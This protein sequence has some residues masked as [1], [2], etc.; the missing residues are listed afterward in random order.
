MWSLRDESLQ[1]YLWEWNKEG[2]GK[3]SRDATSQLNSF[4]DSKYHLYPGPVGNRNSDIAESRM[5]LLLGS[6]VEWNSFYLF[7]FKN[8]LNFNFDLSNINNR[9]GFHCDNP[10]MCTVYIEQFCHL[11]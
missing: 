5:D 10:H 2:C 9:R 8:I 4:S 6:W 1:M 7:V 11:H 3:T